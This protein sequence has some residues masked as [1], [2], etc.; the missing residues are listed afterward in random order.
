M[1][2]FLL[3]VVA[4]SWL[5]VSVDAQ[6]IRVLASETE[7]FFFQQDGQTY[8]QSNLHV[9][10]SSLPFKE[11]NCSLCRAA[12]MEDFLLS[13]TAIFIGPCATVAN[14]RLPIWRSRGF[15]GRNAPIRC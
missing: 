8:F 5:V 10:V 2:E 14:S 11:L 12:K 7:P 4:L 1:R 13:V 9:L 15:S 6:P 3:Y